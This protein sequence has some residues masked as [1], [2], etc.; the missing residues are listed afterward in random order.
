MPTED[1]LRASGWS[2]FQTQW[3]W[4]WDP[5]V[6][7][8]LAWPTPLAVSYR[9]GCGVCLEHSATWATGQ[10]PDGRS[11]S[12]TYLWVR[13]ITGDMTSYSFGPRNVAYRLFVPDAPPGELLPS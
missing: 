10:G 9:W 6:G 2:A 8:W 5:R 11:V 13:D 3:L 12:G 7:R 4:V 1:A